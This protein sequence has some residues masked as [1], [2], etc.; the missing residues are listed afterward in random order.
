MMITLIRT[1]SINNLMDLWIYGFIE[2]MRAIFFHLL[3]LPVER[4][5]NRNGNSSI[6]EQKPT[7]TTNHISWLA[8][9]ISPIQ[10]CVSCPL[11][12]HTNSS[13]NTFIKP[14]NW[15]NL[16]WKS[17]NNDG[18]YNE[19][20]IW[21]SMLEWIIFAAKINHFSC[22]WFKLRLLKFTITKINNRL[23]G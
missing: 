7:V 21:K 10:L 11:T 8:T 3:Q 19:D 18:R 9:F 15:I 13:H 6:P 16:T 4:K 5:A 20:N 22:N 1:H 23:S 17:D 14:M 2:R 12:P